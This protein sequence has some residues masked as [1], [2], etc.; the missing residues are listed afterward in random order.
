[1]LT[2]PDL[3]KSMGEAAILHA[4]QFDWDSATAR[5]QDVF[6]AVVAARQKR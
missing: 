4:R 1:L 6:E 3:R 2:Q 5:W